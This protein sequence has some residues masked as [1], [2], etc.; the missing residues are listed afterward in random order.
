MNKIK[1]NNPSNSFVELY[2]DIVFRQ[3]ENNQPLSGNKQLKFDYLQPKTDYSTPL[4]IFIKG[5]GFLNMYKSKYLPQL[6]YFAQKG[7]AIASI[8]YRTSNE[9]KFPSQLYDVKAAVRYFR[10]N[11]KRYN[12]DS[13]NI[14]VW[15]NSAGGNLASLLGTTNNNK[16]FEGQG[17]HLEFSSEVKAVVDWYGVID[18]LKMP[19]THP[20]SP[21]SLLVGGHVVEEWEKVKQANPITHINQYTPPFLIMHGDSDQ[22]VP[23]QQSHLLYQALKEKN[24]NVEYYVVEGG[25]HS[26]LQFSTKTNALSIVYDFFRKHLCEADY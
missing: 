10:A 7:F 26:F 17:E 9:A 24:R 2:T 15:G 25:E 4:I 8:E 20:D 6:I 11:A 14:G 22:V 13:E 12:I 18:M 19:D 3:F 1:L 16:E 5:G 23:V 21:S